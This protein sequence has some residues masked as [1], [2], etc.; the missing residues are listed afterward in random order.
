MTL[1]DGR[2]EFNIAFYGTEY[3]DLQT[4]VFDGTLGFNVAN[5]GEAEIWGVEMDGRWLVSEGFTL[6]GSLAYLDF[7][8]TEFPLAACY[9]GQAQED[10]GSVTGAGTCDASGERKEYTPEITATLV[11]DYVASIG[12]S[13][14]LRVTVDL[15]YK[16]DYLW[17]PNIDPRSKQDSFVKI[18][19]R[20]AVGAADGKWEVAL[21][22]KNL[23]DEKIANFGGNATLAGALT[24]GTGNAYYAFVDRPL[25]VAVQG[26][27]RF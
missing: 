22:G 26:I 15:S 10:P 18:N 23:T 5:A 2:G 1:A 7:E 12:E 17:S 25:S 3:T 24:G 4:S 9:F 27:Y 19:A 13:M 11:G 8:Y 20:V 14:E 6:S 21:V 16:D